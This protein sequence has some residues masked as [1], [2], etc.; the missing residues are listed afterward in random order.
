[1]RS[2]PDAPARAEQQ[3]YGVEVSLRGSGLWPIA[4][5]GGLLTPSDTEFAVD[6][7]LTELTLGVMPN[8]RG[9]LGRDLIVGL[10]SEFGDAI[11]A[12]IHDASRDLLLPAGT[13]RIEWGAYDEIHSSSYA[14][15]HAARLMLTV[16]ITG[17][18]DSNLLRRTMESEMR[19]WEGT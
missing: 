10:P 7:A 6:L 19:S 18:S 5:I 9:L 12:A 4:F 15:A 3:G 16:H 14:F 1:V 13:M 11:L 2:S 8:F 17:S